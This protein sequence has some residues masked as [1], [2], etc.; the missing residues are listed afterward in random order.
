M[1]EVGADAGVVLVFD[2]VVIVV[3]VVRA[4]TRV[5]FREVRAQEG[6]YLLG[7]SG[8]GEGGAEEG[9][10]LMALL[11]FPFLV[12]CFFFFVGSGSDDLVVVG[13]RRGSV[14]G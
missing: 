13:R 6:G 11:G 1:V 3:I 4:R 8:F 12:F 9:A 7:V 5:G 2:V 14:F 10:V